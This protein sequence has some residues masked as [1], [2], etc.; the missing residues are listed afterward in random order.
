ATGAIVP[1][2]NVLAVE[3]HQQSM[4]SSDIVFGMSLNASV[5]NRVTDTA[6]P[7]IVDRAPLPGAVVNS[8]N[9]IQVAFSE[10]VANV[11]ASD[12]LINNNPATNLQIGR[13][14]V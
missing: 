8:L 13:A 10:G 7:T 5:T 2:D 4:A 9:S 3:V 14:H 1:G 6:A 12:L 11:N